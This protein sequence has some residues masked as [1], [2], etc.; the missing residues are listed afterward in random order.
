[1]TYILSA[2]LTNGKFASEMHTNFNLLVRMAQESIKM[3]QV[4]NVEIHNT[5]GQFM[6]RIEK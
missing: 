2:Q 5:A 1:M 6:H 4:S 3:P